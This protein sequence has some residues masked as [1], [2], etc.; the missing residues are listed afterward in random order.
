M[1]AAEIS[2]L[3]KARDEATSVF[4]KVKASASDLG[5]HM[6]TVLKVGAL[7]AGAGIIGAG[8]ALK[9]FV[10]DAM[11]SQKVMAQTN[12]VLLSTKG[13]A[14]VS[15]EAV[16]SLAD[17]LSRVVP[18]DDEVIQSAENLLLTFTSIGKDIFPQATETVLDMATALKED[19]SSAAIQLGKALQD[20][21][22]GVTALRRVGVALTDSQLA[23][24][25]TLQESGD[26]MGAQKII[27]QELQTEF[28]GSARAAGDTF[29]GKMAILNTQIGNVKERIGLA[30]IPVL[31]K[32]ADL[33]VQFVVPAI[34]SFIDTAGTM[35][36]LIGAFV[37]GDGPAMAEAFAALPGPIRG[38]VH[39]IGELVVF[40]QNSLLPALLSIGEAVVS[41]L[42][43][44]WRDDVVPTL[45]AARGVFDALAPIIAAVA[46]AVF[47]LGR[48]VADKLQ[49]PLEAVLGFM[50]KHKTEIKIFGAAFALL[51]PVVY[52]VAAAH[53]AQAAAATAAAAAEG[54][55]LLPVLL[56]TAALAGLVLGIVLVIKHWDTIRDTTVAVW[57][58]IATVV[59]EKLG[60]LVA[61]FS[62]V[63]A[64]VKAVVLAHFDSIREGITTAISVVR[65]I[66]R[67]VT[68]L[69][70]GDWSEAWAGIKQLASD[71]WFGIVAQAGIAMELL[72]A[73]FSLAWDAI[74][75]VAVLAWNS[76]SDQVLGIIGGL[77]DGA[78]AIINDIIDAINAFAGGINSI[79]GLLSHIPGV[80]EI[81]EIPTIPHVAAG[82]LVTRSGLLLAGE[83]GPEIVFAPQGASVI[84][85]DASRELLDFLR[86]D[87]RRPVTVN[88]YVDRQEIH[89]DPVQALA[90]LGMAL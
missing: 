18:V 87:A 39:A 58:T 2:I 37:S 90:A 65:D 17:S 54:V 14:G 10:S 61:L 70:H 85:S 74:K 3:I 35:F 23:Q 31:S 73:V 71:L 67:I 44:T 83:Q 52:A 47:E 89:G 75:F 30:L 88:V 55:A 59:Q 20:P 21:I 82:G 26:L 72:R 42:V 78:K 62:F 15:A 41:A 48:A 56:I 86:S 45:A 34:E 29:A 12:A 80:P 79:G 76:I 27:L 57:N 53:T 68:A 77:R 63:F 24:I 1:T 25:K 51:V 50:A 7:A 5:S 16:G 13:A 32:L 64:L 66:L 11:E 49:A 60:F 40:I 33:A 22:N 43:T 8:L 6:G 36:E 46:W 28:G 19:T 4:Q 69:I 9:S 84:R 38:V 81:P